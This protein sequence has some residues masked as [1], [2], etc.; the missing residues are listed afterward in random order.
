MTNPTRTPSKAIRE[1]D[2]RASNG[3]DVRLLCVSVADEGVV[4]VQSF[5]FQVAAANALLAFRLSFAYAS[6][7]PA[8]HS[9]VV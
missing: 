7:P 8:G 1:S 3:I 4:A 2:R 6:G 5:Q 9:I